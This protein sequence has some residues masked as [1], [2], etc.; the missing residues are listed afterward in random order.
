[1]APIELVLLE[2]RHR[3]KGPHARLFAAQQPR[4]F[5]VDVGLIGPEVG[6]VDGLFGV[7]DAN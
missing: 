7:G 5:A 1:M 4:V 3:D 2:H 6:N